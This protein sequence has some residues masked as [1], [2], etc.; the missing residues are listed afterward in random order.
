VPS[1]DTVVDIGADKCL[2]VKCREG[3]LLNIAR[4]DRCASGTGRF[5]KVAAAP[6]GL[7]PQEMGN[8]SLISQ[9]TVEITNTCAVFAE[10]EIISLIHQKHRPEDIAKAVFR[11]LA[12]R[13]STLLM[14]V[15]FKPD[16]VIV[17][18]V[19]KNPGMVNAMEEQAG[20]PVVVP[21]EPMITGALGAA[22]LAVQKKMVVEVPLLS[23]GA[24]TVTK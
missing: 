22:L 8:L 1:A 7:D 19:A 5:L 3:R 21:P 17:G 9:R 4:N 6:L 2:V 20:F 24:S 14:K 15:D 11:G 12:G 13:I 18:G 16:L 23:P 10:S